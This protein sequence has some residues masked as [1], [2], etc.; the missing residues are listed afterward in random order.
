MTT[1]SHPPCPATQPLEYDGHCFVMPAGRDADIIDWNNR[2]T[3]VTAIVWGVPVS[4]HTRAIRDRHQ[5]H[6]TSDM[7][8]GWGWDGIKQS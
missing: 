2:G 3:V 4:Q 6:S 1:L 8:H 7:I 5:A